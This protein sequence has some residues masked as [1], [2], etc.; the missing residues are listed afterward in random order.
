MG[1]FCVGVGG[2]RS[3]PL[4]SLSVSLSLHSL[5]SPSSSGSPGR[6]Q[7]I[8]VAVVLRAAECCRWADVW[9]TQAL[10]PLSA[11]C[12]GRDLPRGENP[13]TRCVNTHV[14]VF[15]KTVL[16]LSWEE[17]LSHG[18]RFSISHSPATSDVLKAFRERERTRFYTLPSTESLAVW[19]SLSL[20]GFS[21]L[22]VRLQWTLPTGSQLLSW[23]TRR[24]SQLSFLFHWTVIDGFINSTT[25]QSGKKRTAHRGIQREYWR[26]KW[27][28]QYLP[29]S[30]GTRSDFPRTD[31]GKRW[32]KTDRDS[33][34]FLENCFIHFQGGQQT[35]DL[36]TTKS[37]LR[38]LVFN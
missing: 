38:S 11:L 37:D 17:P 7:T 8:V 13:E 22:S 33:W 29:V 3:V 27:G 19:F 30:T 12:K 4:L 23:V 2:N 26:S 25:C 24:S 21:A 15:S 34:R 10:A 20:R 18:A 36:I 14:R 32:V 6:S 1:V 9:S 5:H 31:R 28:F 16:L 35:V